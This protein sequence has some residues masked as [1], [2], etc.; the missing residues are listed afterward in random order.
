[1]LIDFAM[2]RVASGCPAISTT[3]GEDG[4]N[5]MIDYFISR[6]ASTAMASSAIVRTPTPV[7]PLG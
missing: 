3:I 4:W 2:S 6:Q 5:M 1:M 7:A